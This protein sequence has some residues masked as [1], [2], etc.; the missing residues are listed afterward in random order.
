MTKKRK[1]DS[2][3]NNNRR[4]SLGEV[5]AKLVAVD[6]LTFNQI[7]SSKLLR[8][9]F[10][11]DGYSLPGSRD[12]VKKVFM[13]QF[14]EIQTEIVT[15]IR[16]FKETNNRF[17]ISFDKS[18]TTRNRRFINLNLHFS[19]GFQSLGLIRVKG[20]LRT[21]RA[22]ELVQERL[23]EYALSLN[24]DIVSTITDGASIMMKFG[25]ETVPLHIFCLA[26]AIH[27]SVC[28]VLYTE[29]PK[30]ISDDCRDGG[31][32][33]NT[34]VSDESDGEENPEEKSDEHGSDEEQQNCFDI[35]PEIKEIIKKVRII[36]KIFR[37]SPVKN[38]DNLQPQVQQSFGKEKSLFLDCKIR[39]NSLLN[40]LQRFYEMRKEVKV[41]MLQLDKDFNISCEELDKIKEI[42][43][44]F[45]PLEMAVQYL[46]KENAHL[47]LSEKVI[48]FIIKKLSDL[49]TPFGNALLE[50]FKKRIQE[51]R[52]VEVV[53]LLEYLK[54]LD[55]LKQSVDEFGIKIS[56]NKI[57]NLA[58]VLQQQLFKQQVTTET[59]KERRNRHQI[60]ILIMMAKIRVNLPK[61]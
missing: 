41:A 4:E 60:S 19:V 35:I 44:T 50:S 36:V 20:S 12:Y 16:E 37:K 26:H 31:G 21:E 6:G 27:L 49:K 51:R 14:T 28:D 15:K 17:S 47:I 30:Q 5:V 34:T 25:R 23:H 24:D 10:A 8:R 3:F 18:T 54:S 46:C 52:S 22:I 42:C 7:A 48:V 9:A 13:K 33:G 58:T 45:A 2:Y 61:F 59:V 29:K 39:W 56:K 1:I 40:M 55:F 11:A 32:T 38:D 57:I 53:H 43:D